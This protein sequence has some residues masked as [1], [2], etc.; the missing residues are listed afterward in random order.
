MRQSCDSIPFFSGLSERGLLGRLRE[1]G[2]SGGERLAMIAACLASIQ[3]N[4]CGNNE[5]C[6]ILQVHN[7]KA[8]KQAVLVYEA[9]WNAKQ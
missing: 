6:N 4:A 2:R 8:M 9:I 7:V 5:T 1:G 3:N